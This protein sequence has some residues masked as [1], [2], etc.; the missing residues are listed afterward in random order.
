MA[1]R[2]IQYLGLTKNAHK[3]TIFR[4]SKEKG[5]QLILNVI[6]YMFIQSKFKYK[7]IKQKPLRNRNI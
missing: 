6:K 2:H 1:E 5:K 3:T 4:N 7:I